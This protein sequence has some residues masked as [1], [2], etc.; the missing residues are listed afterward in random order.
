MP[1]RSKGS[2]A[3]MDEILEQV[4]VLT[5][6]QVQL[7]ATKGGEHPPPIPAKLITPLMTRVLSFQLPEVT[8]GLDMIEAYLL[9]LCEA[10]R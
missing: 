2:F 1:T 6:R 4:R 3:A 7:N 9:D 10:G 8:A 5:L